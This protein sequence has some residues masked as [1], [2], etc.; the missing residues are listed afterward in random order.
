MQARREFL[1]AE[2]FIDLVD[3]RAG[4]HR[5]RQFFNDIRPHGALGYQT[6]TAFSAALMNATQQSGTGTSLKGMTLRN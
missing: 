5:Y 6:P 1:N 2:V 3:A 4:G